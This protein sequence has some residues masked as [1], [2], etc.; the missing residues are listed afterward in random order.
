M[1]EVLDNIEKIKDLSEE[2]RTR[3][4]LIAF[5]HDTFKYMEDKSSPR[6]WTKHHAIFARQFMEQF[7]EDEVVLEILELHDE[8]YYVWRSMYLYNKPEQGQQR[9]QRLIDRMGDHLQLYYLFYKCDTKTGDKNP[10]PLKWFEESI[11]GI[12]V[13]PF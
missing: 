10:A 13:V 6:D 9:L 3:L 11:P 7:T 1:R 5:A 8:A 12:T 4:R 2:D